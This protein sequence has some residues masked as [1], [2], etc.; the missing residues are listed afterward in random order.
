MDYLPNFGLIV[1]VGIV[2]F[3]VVAI[4]KTA[5][6]VPQ[7]SA[8][9]IERL[10]KYAN[11]LDAGFHILV[12]F[13]DRVAYKHSL[14]E[15]AVDV[16]SQTCITKDNISVEVDGVLY[17]QVIDPVKASYGID[18]YMF[19]SS[20]LA[21]TTMR[22]EIGKLDL[23]RTFEEREA[24]NS[25][26][27]QAVDKASDPW[28]IKITRYEIK[29]ITPPKSV[30]DALE[31]QMRAERE[32]RAAI[33]ESEGE[34]QAKINVAEG[35]K[36]EAIAKSEGEKQKRINEAEGR[37]KEIMLVAKATSE[38]IKM[39]ASSIDQPGGSEA[40]NLRVAEQY[41]KEFGNLAKINNTMI[42][43]QSLSDVSG[44]I[45]TATSVIGNVKAG[46]DKKE[47]REIKGTKEDG[48][49]SDLTL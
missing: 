42:I 14:K 7:K 49:L 41:I 13:L 25:A 46:K 9:I 18:N 30:K 45:A 33:A 48:D 2:I 40:V 24:I 47:T 15:V 19:A 37:A 21:Q 39:I 8:F 38:G 3:L 12:P 26:I 22:S 36:Q 5:R 28:G 10:G 32:K 35:D 17:M 31:K 23:D 16:E 11:T 20:Q 27:I 43:P 1:A 4:I 34:R 29:N 44:W 6:I